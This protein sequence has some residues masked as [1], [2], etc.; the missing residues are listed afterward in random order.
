MGFHS[1]TQAGMKWYNFGSLQLLN[2][3]LKRSSC[4]SLQSS[5][6]Y[7][8]A[9]PHL[10]NF[11]NLCRDGVLPFCPGWSQA[12]GLKQSAYLS[13]PKRWNYR[14]EPPCYFFILKFHSKARLTV[15]TKTI[16]LNG[17]MISI[18]SWK[19]ILSFHAFPIQIYTLKCLDRLQNTRIP[20]LYLI[21]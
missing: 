11:C 9:P 2:P 6:D 17:L 16:T 18:S 19:F 21:N 4:L 12:P 14:W 15:V 3:R 20:C 10:A 13:L 5:W 1:V 8:C 7:R